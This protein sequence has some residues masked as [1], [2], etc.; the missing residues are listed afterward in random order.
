MRPLPRFDA[1]RNLA[2]QGGGARGHTDEGP[3]GVS[4]AQLFDQLGD[5]ER[6]SVPGGIRDL[7]GTQLIKFH[8]L[9]VN[10]PGSPP[11]GLA[12]LTGLALDAPQE[13]RIVLDGYPASTYMSHR[14]S[15]A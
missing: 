11:R 9:D 7:C 1:A 2:E 12:T 10:D 15:K 8:E 5:I 6:D 13:S 4:M 14:T 3:V